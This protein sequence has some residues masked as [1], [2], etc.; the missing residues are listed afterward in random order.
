[1]AGAEEGRGVEGRAWER[2]R[3]WR[4]LGAVARN[5]QLILSSRKTG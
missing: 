4:P 3:A 2:P 1:M 5:L